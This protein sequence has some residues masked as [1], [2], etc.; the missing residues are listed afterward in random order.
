[1]RNSTAARERVVA[2]ECMRRLTGFR[3]VEPLK[4]APSSGEIMNFGLFL[5]NRETRERFGS[6]EFRE[7]QVVAGD[8]FIPENI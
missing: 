1:M 4:T 7:S 6:A 2:R 8:R 3:I 5:H